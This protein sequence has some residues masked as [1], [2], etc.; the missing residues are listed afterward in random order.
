MND[1]NKIIIALADG[2]KSS[3]Q[4]GIETKL[5]PGTLYPLLMELERE[6]IIDSE[7]AA[8]PYPRRRIYRLVTQLAIEI[9]AQL[10]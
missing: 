6:K 5:W 2:P 8:G 7:F 1:K 4:L 10:F 3:P 9:Q